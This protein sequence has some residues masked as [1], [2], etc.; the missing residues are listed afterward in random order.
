MGKTGLVPDFDIFFDH[1]SE[2]SEKTMLRHGTK[3]PYDRFK[4]HVGQNISVDIDAWRNF[5]QF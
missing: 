2:L 1:G 3:L 4:L 5:N